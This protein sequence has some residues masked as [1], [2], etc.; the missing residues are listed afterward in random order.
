MRRWS[1]LVSEQEAGLRV[2]RF[3]RLKLP[4]AARSEVLSWCASGLVRSRGRPLRKGDRLPAGG[5]VEVE[6]PP[7]G[8]AGPVV[9]EPEGRLQVLWEDGWLA[10]VAKPAG[11]A[12]HPL[13]QGE[14]GT[15]AN[16]LVARYPEMQ[17][18]GYSALEP[19]VLHR[20]DRDTSGVL[21][22]ARTAPAFDRMREGFARRRVV[23]IYLAAVWGCPAPE[24]VVSLAIGSR[25]RRSQ[26][27][28]TGAGTRAPGGVRSLHPAETSYRLVRA[29]EQCSLVRAVMRTG[30]RHQIRAHM[31]ALG[32]PVVGDRLY[33]PPP[34]SASPRDPSFGR[35]LLHA[36]EIRFSHP[37]DGRE[38]RIRCPL[39]DDF[40]EFLRA[41]GL[42]RP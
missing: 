1:F 36:S 12:T 6:G 37:G 10:A 39:P 32:H 15:V 35:H 28:V 11:M 26:R 23:K 27:V 42:A 21:L 22:A 38:L 31:A 40:R 33:G 24:G 30:V 9:P 3:L 5:C 34:V 14:T 17:G 25:G 29:G 4:D 8:D 13:R 18:V 7:P 2:D 20:L 41:R 16:A 19:G